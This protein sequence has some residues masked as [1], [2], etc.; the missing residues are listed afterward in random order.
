L[1]GWGDEHSAVSTGTTM[2]DVRGAE[3]IEKSKPQPT[4]PIAQ[5]PVKQMI[6]EIFKPQVRTVSVIRGGVETKVILPDVP[7]TNVTSND[8]RS[9]IK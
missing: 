5:T 7:E 6:A 8:L 9:A 3:K 2:S 1:R 4:T